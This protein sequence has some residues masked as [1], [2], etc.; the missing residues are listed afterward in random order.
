MT[1]PG[2]DPTVQSET[3]RQVKELRHTQNPV[4]T[5]HIWRPY[6]NHNKF[7]I[8]ISR[9]RYFLFGLALFAINRKQ[10][11]IHWMNARPVDKQC[12]MVLED[13]RVAQVY[14]EVDMDVSASGIWNRIKKAVDPLP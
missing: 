5:G 1:K 2:V 12:V 11:A 6:S 10:A 3:F 4:W 8:L 7:R 9:S 13:G 14:P